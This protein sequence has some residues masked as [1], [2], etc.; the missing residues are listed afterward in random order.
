M[1]HPIEKVLARVGHGFFQQAFVVDDI[2]RAQAACTSAL[3][4]STF[5]VLAASSLPYR[6]RGRDVECALAL[7]FGRSGDVQIELIQPVDGEGIHVEFLASHGPGAHHLGYQVDD[8]DGELAAAS[9]VG[10]ANVM[11]GTFG[12]LRFAYLDTWDAFGAYVELVH[13]PEGLMAQ[14]MPWGA[15]ANP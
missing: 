10:F 4:C 2:E 3:G 6:Y 13:D 14:L 15:R 7:A 11:S 12:S 5:A 9:A 8:L 1:G